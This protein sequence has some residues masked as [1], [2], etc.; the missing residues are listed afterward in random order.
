MKLSKKLNIPISSYDIIGHIALVYI[1][2]EYMDRANE[3]AKSIIE[4]H[5]RVKTVYR[6]NPVYGEYRLRDLELI[7]GEDISETITKEN[8]ITLKLDV[9]KVFYSPRMAYDRAK[10]LEYIKQGETVLVGFAGVGPYPILIKKKFPMNKVIGIEI[11]E[12]AYKYFLENIK[13]NKVDVEVILGDFCKNIIK[14]DRII[15]PM[16]MGGIEY[17]K[18]INQEAYIHTY[19]FVDSKNPLE[20]GKNQ[21]SKYIRDFK[22]LDYRRLRSYSKS[23]DE[24]VFIIS[25]HSANLLL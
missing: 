3:I 14:A 16:P 11:N 13:I 1:P 15:M 4:Q 23:L 24:Y 8:G 22:I 17:L 5:P 19:L 10:T 20:D 12:T 21:I 18:C 6:K 2:D 25:N 9:K 7:Y